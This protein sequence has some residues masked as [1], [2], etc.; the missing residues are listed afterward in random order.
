MNKQ[1]ELIHNT[2]WDYLII[3]D[4]CRYDYFQE[5]NWFSGELQPVW[6]EGSATDAWFPN[7]FKK[8]VDAAMISAHPFFSPVNPKKLDLKV[9]NP[10]I[11]VE[12]G[13]GEGI[14][15]DG[16]EMNL[17]YPEYTTNK[18]LDFI[19]SEDKKAVIHY[20]QP[21]A[22]FLGEPEILQ[23]GR[24]IY[25]KVKRGVLSLD[26]VKEAYKGNLIYVLKEAEKIIEKV[27]ESKVVIT[28]DHGELLGEYGFYAHPHIVTCN[29]LRKVPW[30]TVS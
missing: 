8:P 6:S 28:A 1:K 2:G 18:A 5:V 13:V 12:E 20:L 15:E 4:A 3:L 9:F 11:Y 26:F 14:R 23:P 29:E 21:H 30:F 7:T 24:F 25:D 22:P 19:K 27:S 17:V 10:H 16:G